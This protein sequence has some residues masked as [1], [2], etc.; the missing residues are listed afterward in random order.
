MCS[1]PFISIPGLPKKKNFFEYELKDLL[2]NNPGNFTTSFSSPKTWIVGIF[3]MSRSSLILVYKRGG[4]VGMSSQ[5]LLLR[6][7]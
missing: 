5:Q 1:N 6:R 2:M 4:R 7:D 3:G